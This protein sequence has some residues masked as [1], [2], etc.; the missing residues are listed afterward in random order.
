MYG[1]DT[2]E[3]EHT[4]YERSLLVGYNKVWTD[5]LVMERRHKLCI[6]SRTEEIANSICRE[7]SHLAFAGVVALGPEVHVAYR[8]LDVVEEY[9]CFGTAEQSFVGGELAAEVIH[10]TYALNLVCYVPFP[11]ALGY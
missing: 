8:T 5:V 7:Q 9:L 1:F 11:I 4:V 6:A 2:A 3:V 10:V